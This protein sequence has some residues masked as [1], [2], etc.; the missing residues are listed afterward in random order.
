MI[1][2]FNGLSYQT[3]NESEQNMN[4]PDITRELVELHGLKSDE[5]DS[6]ISIIGRT[7]TF[8]ELGIFSA[9]WNEH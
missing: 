9:M 4:E 7:P 1:A 5:Y 6:I 8:T 2:L 3:I